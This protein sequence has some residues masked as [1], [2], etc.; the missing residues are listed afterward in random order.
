M[1]VDFSA[2]NGRFIYHNFKVMEE[3]GSQNNDGH[4]MK[5]FQQFIKKIE[6]F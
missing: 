3:G 6:R 5:N 4:P 1:S 2:D